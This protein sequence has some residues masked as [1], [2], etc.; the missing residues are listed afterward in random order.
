MGSRARQLSSDSLAKRAMLS[1]I[2]RTLSIGGGLCS[3]LGMKKRY[4]VNLTAVE[5]DGLS[6]IVSKRRVSSWKQ[7]RAR[8]LLKADEGLTDAEI[9]E[10][11]GVGLV[12]VE[13]VRKRCCE[14]GIQACLERKAQDLPSRPRKLDGTAEAHLVLLACSEPPMGRVRWTLGLLADRLVELNIFDNV[15]KS[16][17]QR[18]LKKMNSS[19]GG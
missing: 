19:P 13:R 15:S 5:R 4:V 8:I 17:I 18:A 9:A 6:E 1:I 11:V 3:I 10:D 16:T 12:T 14:L 7:T 2:F